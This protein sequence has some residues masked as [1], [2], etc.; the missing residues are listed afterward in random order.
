MQKPTAQLNVR[1]PFDLYE[2]VDRLAARYGGTKTGVI[3][4]AVAALKREEAARSR[5]PKHDQNTTNPAGE[6]DAA[7][8]L[9]PR[10]KGKP[11]IPP[12]GW[13]DVDGERI[14]NAEEQTVLSRL[15]A[16]AREGKRQGQIRDTLNAE[17]LLNRGGVEWRSNTVDTV[18]RTARK[19]GELST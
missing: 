18:L 1:V 16:L 11:G 14:P 5:M 17:G 15:L 6:D 4:A 13:H 7:E 3:I 10:R 8:P 19:R 12:F 2:D 9:V